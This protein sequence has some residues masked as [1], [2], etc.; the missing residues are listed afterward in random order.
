MSAIALILNN[1]FTVIMNLKGGVC[2]VEKVPADKGFR[3]Y[4]YTIG[5][6]L[7]STK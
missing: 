1:T 2:F 5:H 3:Y 4:Y 7:L 6:G